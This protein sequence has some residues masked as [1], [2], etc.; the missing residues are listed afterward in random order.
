MKYIVANWKSNLLPQQTR[1]QVSWWKKKSSQQWP[2][3][4]KLII[5]G[6]WT[7][8]MTSDRFKSTKVDWGVQNLSV[9][10]RGAYTGE[11]AAETL[12]NLGFKY[13][14]IGHSERRRLLG[15]TDSDI[16]AKLKQAVTHKIT[17]IVC[18]GETVEERS[19]GQTRNALRRQIKNIFSDLKPG[20]DLLIAYEPAWAISTQRVDTEINPVEMGKTIG[21]LKQFL[22]EVLPASYVSTKVR[23]IYGG[24]VDGKNATDLLAAGFDGLLV[25]GASLEPVEL[26][27]IINS[28]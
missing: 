10:G 15:E 6:G 28:K 21:I 8:Y 20:G 14:I 23:I 19:A 16:S 12:K 22:T 3:K 24:S 11:A 5:C 17:P 7:D 1:Q 4:R 25:G 18:I 9:Y 2:V 13:S 26:W 27:K